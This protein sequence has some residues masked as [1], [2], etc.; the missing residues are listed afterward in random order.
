MIMEEDK[1]Y[2]WF[3]STFL[4][5]KI[6]ANLSFLKVIKI[7]VLNEREIWAALFFNGTHTG[8]IC[9]LFVCLLVF[10][11]MSKKEKKISV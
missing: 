10:F 6:T 9:C 8:E 4:F 1:G 7:L 5:S 3:P 2:V 11:F